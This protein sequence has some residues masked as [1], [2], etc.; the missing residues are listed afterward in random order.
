MTLPWRLST[1]SHQQPN[2]IWHNR[3]F[4]P[5]FPQSI[6]I[7]TEIVFAGYPDGIQAAD[8]AMPGMVMRRG[9]LAS[10][11]SVNI[12]VPGALGRDYALIDAFSQNGFSGS[13]VFALIHKNVDL[14]KTLSGFAEI[15]GGRRGLVAVWCRSFDSVMCSKGDE[16]WAQSGRMNFAR[17]RCGSR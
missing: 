4:N 16:P 6:G 1:V 3:V 15:L 17:M 8:A 9:I 7:G 10:H 14:L 2:Y 11:L 12:Y 5:L 13:P